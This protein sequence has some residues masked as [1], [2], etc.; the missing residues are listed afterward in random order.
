MKR[1]AYTNYKLNEKIVVESTEYKDGFGR[2]IWTDGKKYYSLE[3]N[4][5]HYGVPIKWVV[6]SL[7]DDIISNAEKYCTHIG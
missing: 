4:G 6:C 1:T 7:R 2:R 5:H 3:N